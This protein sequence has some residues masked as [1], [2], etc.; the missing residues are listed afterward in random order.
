MPGNAAGRTEG[1][2]TE[3]GDG[4]AVYGD[5]APVHTAVRALGK[6]GGRGLCP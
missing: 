4:S 2:A 3:R 6:E 5:A 1:G